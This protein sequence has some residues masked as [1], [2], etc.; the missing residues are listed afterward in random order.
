[1]NVLALLAVSCTAPIFAAVYEVGPESPLSAIGQVPWATLQP[2]DTVLIHYRSM[3]YRE[4][5][6]ICRQGTADSPI[7]IR[8]VPGPGGEL[9]VIDG[10]GAVTAPGLNFWSEARGVIK[11]GGANIPSDT[12]PRHITI[13]NLEIRSARG[14]Y[15]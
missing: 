8:G 4:K 7:A 10:S 1:M 2:G 13:E 12:T 11:V 3:P 14:A 5:W 15:T 6:V 9:P